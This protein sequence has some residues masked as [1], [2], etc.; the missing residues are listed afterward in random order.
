MSYESSPGC[1][2]VATN[3]ACCGKALVDAPSLAAGM[4]PICRKKHG[5]DVNCDAATRTEVNTIVYALAANPRAADVRMKLAR[6][7]ALDFEKLAKRIS[8]RLGSAGMLT[9]TEVDGELHLAAPYN[10]AATEHLRRVPGRQWDATS[11]VN[12]FPATSRALLLWAMRQGYAGA[13]VSGPKGLFVLE[14]LKLGEQPPARPQ[15]PVST[16]VEK[17]VHV[18][19]DGRT[20]LVHAPY[21]DRSTVLFRGIDGRRWDARAK[22]NTFPMRALTALKSVLVECYGA[23]AIEWKLATANLGHLGIEPQMP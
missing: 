12:R 8:K 2:L 13:T 15:V 9:I 1:K 7:V 20:L 21:S 16:K 4:G 17:T 19:E 22:V 18:I 3:C 5:F 11:K 6:L 23:A 14:A 10:P